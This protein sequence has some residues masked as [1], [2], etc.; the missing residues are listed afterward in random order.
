MSCVARSSRA[1]A[2]SGSAHTIGLLATISA[3]R[4]GGIDRFQENAAILDQAIEGGQGD[5]MMARGWNLRRIGKRRGVHLPP[6]GL[7]PQ[8]DEIVVED[9]GVRRHAGHRGL[10]AARI[11]EEGIAAIV[12]GEARGVKEQAARCKGQQGESR[13][14]EVIGCFKGLNCG[15]GEVPASGGQ[16]RGRPCNHRR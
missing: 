15:V 10:A 4:H 1:D 11:A 5:V 6:I 12:I 8:H 13:A 7:G 9:A 16:R 2:R 14:H 3:S